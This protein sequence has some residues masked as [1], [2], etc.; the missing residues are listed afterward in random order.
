MS[1][2][3]WIEWLKQRPQP[4]KVLVH[5]SL[6]KPPEELKPLHRGNRWNGVAGRIAAA[7]A[8]GTVD[9]LDAL[10]ANGGLIRSCD[11]EGDA[12]EEGEEDETGG[13]DDSTG[14]PFLKHMKAWD[15]RM[16]ERAYAE[17]A[18]LDRHGNYM[19]HAFRE[20]VA[21]S[22]SQQ[23]HLVGLVE[24]LTA[25]L[26]STITSLHTVSVN[27]ANTMA[28]LTRQGD[29]EGAQAS[30]NSEMLSRVL[31]EAA[32]RMMTGGPNGAPPPGKKP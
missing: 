12:I 30:Q 19:M 5:F 9:H 10:D 16:A 23:E 11:A 3:D 18:V 25:H 14:G 13:E 1:D 22:S 31:G 28:S 17:A 7:V 27:F 29:D 2:V 20:G 15:R 8:A 21:A 24:T 32:A 4:S 6:G 26:S